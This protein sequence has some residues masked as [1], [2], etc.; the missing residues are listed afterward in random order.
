MKKKDLAERLAAEAHVPTAT[1][2]DE[3]DDAIH[4][5]LCALREHVRP[6]PSPLERLIHEALGCPAAKRHGGKP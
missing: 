6:R 4:D 2:A 3:L 1:A 5:L